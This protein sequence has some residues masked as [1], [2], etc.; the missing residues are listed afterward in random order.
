MAVFG[1]APNVQAADP[2]ASAGF[3][4]RVLGLDVMTASGSVV[5]FASSKNSNVRITVTQVDP[6]SKVL[7]RHDDPALALPDYIV[8]VDD[9][10]GC[11]DRAEDRGC[12]ILRAVGHGQLG[13]TKLPRAGPARNGG[14]GRADARPR[15]KSLKRCWQ[16]AISGCVGQ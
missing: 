7:G 1:V 6:L 4:R 5:T 3:Y 8:E 15:R 14:Q 13:H 12:P 11:Y 10:E 2:L 9:I 16:L